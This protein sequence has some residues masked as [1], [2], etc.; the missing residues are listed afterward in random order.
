MR[1][2]A[3]STPPVK[4]TRPAESSAPTGSGLTRR[5]VVIAGFGVVGLAG[6]GV[7]AGFLTKTIFPQDVIYESPE[8]ITAQG[9]ELT[10]TQACV[11][12]DDEE[13][14]SFEEG[15]Y[16][17]A[18][19]PQRSNFR[20]PGHTGQELAV[21]GRVVDT[22]CRPIPGAVLDFWQVNEHGVYDNVGYNYRGHQFTRADGTYELLTLLPI[23]YV[24]AGLWRAA[25]IH[26]KV[27]GPTTGLLT[28]QMFFDND[29]AG[30]AKAFDFDKSLLAKVKPGPGGSVQTVFNFVLVAS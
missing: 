14:S 12:D 17:T 27:Q 7:G 9:V 26:V 24:F 10:P 4:P 18:H 1:S 8:T 11:D 25:H 28:S 15:P 3:N 16:Y 19:S 29:P 22:R 5:D 6:F 20:Q 23:P 13:T 30:N 21:R 2:S